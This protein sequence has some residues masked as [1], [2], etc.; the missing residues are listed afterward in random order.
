[1]ECRKRECFV[2][3]FFYLTCWIF[4]LEVVFDS[5]NELLES[6]PMDS[7]FL[8]M[9]EDPDRKREEQW[10]KASKVRPSW[11]WTKWLSRSNEH[12]GSLDHFF[13]HRYFSVVF[14]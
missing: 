8:V 3:F 14:L 1:M 10:A 5:G 13:H 11:A 2:G 4:F 12:D 7:S 6:S 9:T